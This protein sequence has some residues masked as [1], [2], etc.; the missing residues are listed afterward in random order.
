MLRPD[1]R[2]PNLEEVRALV[3]PEMCCA[4]FSMLVAEQLLKDA[5]YGERYFFGAEDD[6]DENDQSKMT[7]EVIIFAFHVIFM[8]LFI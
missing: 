8:F 2:L 7:D 4:G 1:Y 3:T 5:G 6:E